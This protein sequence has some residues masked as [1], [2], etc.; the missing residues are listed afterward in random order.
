M[1][2]RILNLAVALDRLIFC[3]LTF[4]DSDPDETMSGAAWRLEQQGRWQGKLFRPLIDAGAWLLAGQKEHC[5]KAYFAE[6]KH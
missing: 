1:R 4:G 3:I 5:R 6:R 2:R